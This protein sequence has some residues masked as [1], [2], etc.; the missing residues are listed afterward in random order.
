MF[1]AIGAMMVLWLE[2][3]YFQINGQLNFIV[4]MNI[5]HEKGEETLKE[6]IRI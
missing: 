2:A 4:W 1:M 5:M 6:L 3:K